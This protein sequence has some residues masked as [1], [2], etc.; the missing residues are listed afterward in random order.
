[1][2]K[3]IC[4]L[5]FLLLSIQSN[6]LAQQQRDAGFQ[7]SVQNWFSAWELVS[8]EVYGIHQ[9]HE[10]DFVFFDNQFLYSTSNISIPG[11]ATIAGLPLLNRSFE[12]YQQ[13]H[14][15]SIRLPDSSVIPVGLLSFAGEAKGK[16]FF[17]MPLPSFW[18][19]AGVK[20]A[21][22]GL[23]NLVTGVFLHEFSHA[24]QMQNFGKQMSKD[25]QAY[26]FGVPFDDDLIQHIYGKDSAY[27]ALF[28]QELNA[29]YKS[30]DNDILDTT[31]LKHG[32]VLME[33]RWQQYLHRKQAHLPVL[34]QFFLTMEGVGQYSMYSW[35]VHPK[36]ANLDRLTAMNGVRRGKKWWSQEEGLAMFLALERLETAKVWGQKMF[37]DEIFSVIQLL[38]KAILKTTN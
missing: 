16:A 7:Q 33:Q 22:L 12:W 15:D 1:M 20:S 30:V 28:R 4:Y 5:C 24:Q 9:L 21:E 38:R 29:F 32:L 31:A 26:D 13:K 6:S 18:E 10:V 14:G 35:L 11:G 8:K 3:Y 23:S 25:E 37:G 34:D 17:V 36:G 27:V 19:E 2:N